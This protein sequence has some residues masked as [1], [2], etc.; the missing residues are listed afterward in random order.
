MRDSD[1]GLLGGQL[2]VREGAAINLQ[3]KAYIRSIRSDDIW[4]LVQR[5]CLEC[6][7]HADAQATVRTAPNRCVYGPARR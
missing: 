7:L 1:R 3:E 6:W 4:H 5:L 2:E